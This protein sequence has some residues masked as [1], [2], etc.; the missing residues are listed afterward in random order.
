MEKVSPKNFACVRHLPVPSNNNEKKKILQNR[1]KKRNARAMRSVSG[2]LHHFFFFCGVCVVCTRAESSPQKHNFLIAHYLILS[3]HI[4]VRSHRP[5]E[6]IQYVP[7]LHID[8]NFH[9]EGDASDI[10]RFDRSFAADFE[11]MGTFP[12][13]MQSPETM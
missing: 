10:R 11:S 2:F 13:R 12:N 1:R 8:K 7:Q 6:R 3:F 5:N 9:A 4:A